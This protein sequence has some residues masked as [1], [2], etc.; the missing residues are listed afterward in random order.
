MFILLM[1]VSSYISLCLVLLSLKVDFPDASTITEPS[2]F[3]CRFSD[4]DFRGTYGKLQD[5]Y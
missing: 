5:I 3:H 1:I 2:F 4:L